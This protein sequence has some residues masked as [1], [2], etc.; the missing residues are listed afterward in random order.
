MTK[1][2]GEV[3]G[4]PHWKET[5][6][7][8][9]QDNDASVEMLRKYHQISEET[10][11]DYSLVACGPNVALN[12]LDALGHDV[13][14]KTPGQWPVQATDVLLAWFFDRRNTSA[15]KAAR[16]NIEPFEYPGQ[17]IPQYYPPA[18]RDVFGVSCV[19]EWGASWDQVSRYL[20]MGEGVQ[21]CLK[22]PGHFIAAVAFDPGKGELIYHDPWPAR[23]RSDG[24][25]LRMGV[26]EFQAN[27]Q[28]Y[29]I[30]Y[31]AP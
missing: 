19:F 3:F 30:R 9:R 1:E 24:K 15:M 17:T 11:V 26:S 7:Y 12:I 16:D 2:D 6:R 20:Y 25:G 28:P 13:T 4:T 8:Y 18:V 23:T 22:D 10:G 21:I 27:I 31:F 5:G 29:L 14:I